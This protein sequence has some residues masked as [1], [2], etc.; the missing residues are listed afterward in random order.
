M[1]KHIYG[2]YVPHLSFEFWNLINTCKQLTYWPYIKI[3]IITRYLTILT[4]GGGLKNIYR[5]NSTAFKDY[6][7]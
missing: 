4:H 2:M 1:Y 3:D 7:S 6:E 5:A